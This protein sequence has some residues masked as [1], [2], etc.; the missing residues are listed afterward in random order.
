[1]IRTLIRSHGGRPP[2]AV[3]AV[4]LVLA[5]G[6][7]LSG[8]ASSATATS[9]LTLTSE[10]VA[11][12]LLLPAFRCEPKVDG[13]EAS[14]P[15]AWSNVPAG[16]GSLAVVMHHYLFPDDKTKVS[17]YLLL[18]DIDPSVTSIAHGAADDGPWHMGANKDGV[19]V[20][21]TSP[22]SKRAGA[23]E[24]TITL[25]ALASTPSSLPDASTVDVT[26]DVLTKA[27]G[28]VD[29]LGTATLTFTDPG[30]TQGGSG[31]APAPSGQPGGQQPPPPGGGQGGQR[32]PAASTGAGYTIEQAISDKA[33]STTIAFDALGFLTGNL[34][35]DSFFPPGKVADFWGFQYLRD[36]DTSEMGHNTDFL[37]SASLN[38][39]NLLTTEQRARLVALAK[40]QVSSIN[41]YGYKRFVLMK[42]FRRLLESD[43]PSGTTGLSESAVKAYS[44]ELYALDGKI[45]LERAQVMG[46]MLA[47]LTTSQRATL[48]AMKGTGMKTW[49][50]ATEPSDLQGLPRD[51]KVAVMTYAGDMFSWY[52]GDVEADTYFCPERHGTYFGSFYLK[53]APAVGNPGYSIGTTIT[54]DLGANLLAKLDATQAAAIS[55]LVDSQRADLAKIVETRRAVSTELRTLQSG[56]TADA[57]AVAALMKTYGELDGSIVYQYA[58]AFASVGKTLT[59]TEKADLLAMRRTLL[60]DLSEPTTAFLFS[61]PIEMP[62]IPDTDS[63]FGPGGSTGTSTTTTA[64]A[65]PSLRIARGS[66]TTLATGYG[67]ATTVANGAAVTVRVALSPA[68]AGTVVRL[69]QRIGA[70]GAWKSVATGRT[71]ATGTAAWSRTM[72]VRSTATGSGRS[73]YFRVSVPAATAGAV[74]WSRLVRAVVK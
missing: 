33:Q 8:C 20:S 28:T 63:L 46:P 10:A 41:D 69:Y 2:G 65:V 34:S 57:A 64:A 17:S 26:Y 55:G 27:I 45:S 49:P 56:G 3:A 4:A 73:V 43:L 13:V 31:A 39:L 67:T 14:I 1:M 24:Y 42:A 19:T 9:S 60:G 66:G 29:V 23:H 53:D 44:A 70:A 37:T 72:R 36:N 59:T 7:A 16:T 38:M 6:L 50:T 51:E 74:T 15:L 30:D 52:V 68:V 18:W 40:S 11:G 48:D 22:C 32:G 58:N 61:Q 5:A 35:S 54:A 12:G 21:Y 25:Y 62:T 47:S 71:S